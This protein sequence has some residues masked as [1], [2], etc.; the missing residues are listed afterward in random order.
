MLFLIW[1][2]LIVFGLLFPK[3]RIISVMMV[4]F[5]ILVTGF[6]TQGADY[7]IYQNEFAWAEYQVFSDVHYIGYLVLEQLAHQH[8]IL[9]EQFMFLVGS[10]SCL[11]LYWGIRQLTPYVNAVLALFFVYPF[12]HES[13]QTRT[14]LANAVL[15]AAL[16]LILKEDDE[17]VA[18]TINWKGKRVARI[19]TFYLISI[20]ACSFHFEAVIYVVLLSLMLFLPEKYGR[21]FIVT[22]TVIAFVLIE[23]GIFPRLVE[24]FNG[25][26]AYWL[27][28]RTGLGIVIPIFIS[29]VIWYAMQIA[30]KVCVYN[31]MGNSSEQKFYKSLLRFSDFIFL[32]IPFFCYDITFNRL[33][34][35]FLLLLYMMVAK[36]FTIK[37]SKNSRL[38]IV[39]LI[40]VLFAS[41]CIYEGVFKI[42]L[43]V[44]ENNAIM[45]NWAVF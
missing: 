36:T 31:S 25:R 37:I 27:S 4:G 41:V 45:G 24:R 26:I 28:S 16:P 12:S 42:L 1:G 10:A 34:R 18:M 29:L 19:I 21:S 6:R 44:F 17:K 33:W 2:I 40:I 7:I 38:W 9:F 30:G 3:S 11:L 23:I 20:V 32:L 13:V 14:F 39:F 35:I 15:I 22:S 8:S 5:M 43:G